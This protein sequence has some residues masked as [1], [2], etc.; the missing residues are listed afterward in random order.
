V[1][2]SSIW[3]FDTPYRISYRFSIVTDSLSPAVFEMLGPK[4]IGVTTLTF[5]VTRRHR[6]HDDPIRHM[7]FHISAPLE[8]SPYLQ[9]FSRYL[10]P[11]ISLSRAWP[12]K[13]TWCH[14]TPKGQCD[15][16]RHVTLKGQGRD[17]NM[18]R[19]QYHMTHVVSYWCSIETKSYL[20]A[21][22]RYLAPN[23]SGSRPWPFGVTWRHWSCDHLMHHIAFPIGVPL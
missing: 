9:A 2:S 4:H 23:I 6:S 21:F 3:P 11:I 7:Q 12:F 14:E 19:A 1:T 5:Q 8:P 17:P 13:V 18:L 16:W 20:Q 22:S 15:R 10:A